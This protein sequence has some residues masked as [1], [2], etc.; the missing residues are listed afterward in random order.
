[1]KKIFTLLVFI[2]TISYSQSDT[3]IVLLSSIDPEIVQDVKYATEDNF[4][5]KILY[6]TAKVYLRKI[7]A[8]KL[9]QASDYLE[10]NHGLRIKIFDGYRPHSVQIRMWEIFP[11]PNYVANPA[12]GSKHGRGAAVDITLIDKNGNELDMGTPYDTFNEKAHFASENISATARKNR[13]LLRS[14]MKKFGFKGISTEWWHFD[15]IG[16]E[17]YSILDIPIK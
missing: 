9:S 4:T 17:K 14:V 11:N 1:M 5:G 13:D 2:C 8:E 15:L 7:T 3:A 12:K 10:K 16:W 6:P